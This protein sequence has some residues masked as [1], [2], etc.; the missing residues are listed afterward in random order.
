MISE[1]L[2]IGNNEYEGIK[3]STIQECYDYCFLQNELSVDIE[4]TRKYPI[5]TYPDWDRK[6][7]VYLAGLDPHL[8]KIVMLQIGT[9]EKIFVIDVRVIDITSLIPLFS[10]KEI[11]F[12]GQNLKFEAKHLRHNYGINFYKIWDVMLVEQ[13]LTNGMDLGYS[14]AKISERYLGIKNVNDIDLF[15]QEDGDEEVIDKSI[16]LEFLTIGDAPFTKEQVTYGAGD[17]EYP[18]RIKKIQEQGING[19]NPTEVHKLENDFC[20]VLAD[21]ELNGVSFS[22]KQWLQTYSN[23]VPVYEKRL[24]KLNTWIEQKHPKF[25]EPATLFEESKGC[26]ILW[27]SPDQVIEFLKYLKICPKEKSKQTKRM[28]WTAGAKALTKLLNSDYK[29]KYGDNEETEI[30][31]VEDFILNYLLLNKSAQSITTFGEDWLKYIH[32]ITGRIHTSFRQILS[33]GRISSNNPNI[34]N[35]PG[36]VEYRKAFIPSL[37]NKFINSDFAAQEVRILSEV[38]KDPSMLSFFNDGHPIFKDDFHCFVASKMFS[39]IRNEPDLIVTKKTHPKER[40]DAKAIS[41]K[42]SYGGSAYT[43]KDDFG[44]VEEV[45]QK[46]IDGFFEAFPSLKRNF[47]EAMATA[48]KLGY[49]E[50]DNITKRRWFFKDFKKMKSLNDKAWSLYPENYSKLTKEKKEL[51]KKELK[52]THPELK[53]IWS[54]Y[55]SLKGKLERN[56]LNYR[57]QGLAGSQT[58]RAGVLFREHQLKNNLQNTTWLVSLIHDEALSETIPEYAEK[59]KILLEN[60]MVNGAQEYCK[61]VK[62]AAEGFIVDWWHHD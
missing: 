18:L 57:I 39:V 3:N 16:R 5:G 32:P 33:T 43:L 26:R 61:N 51:V 40:Q 30:N 29:K 10:N 12:I 37:G 52:E 46:F 25:S 22:K 62:M 47:E 36:D 21:I 45:A 49:I 20:L 19:Y 24:K 59:A 7:H 11:T 42:I 41:F 8:S 15:N 28:E 56:A 44:V 6:N 9:L 48:M 60:C 34:Q 35:I 50:I 23:N 31:S 2:F 55:F 4:T 1:I 27:S 53:D 13:N 38:S 14:L 17:I 58:K 54:E